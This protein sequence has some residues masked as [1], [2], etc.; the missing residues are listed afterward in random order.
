VGSLKYL[1]LAGTFPRAPLVVIDALATLKA[2]THLPRLERR[3]TCLA[4][5]AV[6]SDAL[7][8][9]VVF[10]ALGPGTFA[11]ILSRIRSV[12][13]ANASSAMQ[14]SSSR[15]VLMLL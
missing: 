13:R 9:P 5:R 12:D 7:N 11:G 15:F 14:R 4:R 1:Q 10:D 2:L 8:A 3:C 6:A